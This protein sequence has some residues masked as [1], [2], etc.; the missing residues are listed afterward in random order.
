MA[1]SD[2]LT[3]THSAEMP[4][5]YDRLVGLLDGTLSTRPAPLQ[6]IPLLGVGGSKTYVVRTFRETRPDE[7]D[8]EKVKAYFYISLQVTGR[9]GTVRLVLPPKVA[10]LISRQRESLTTIA[11]KRGA[12]M[13]AAARKRAGIK[14]FVKKAE[15][16]D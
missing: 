6:V 4:D 13:K 15:G 9:D 14:P 2:S 16:V 3:H 11:R 1:Q 8:P 7:R 12:K 5:E 10:D